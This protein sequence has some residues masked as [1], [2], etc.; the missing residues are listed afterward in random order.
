MGLKGRAFLAIW[1]GLRDGAATEFE[2][3]HTVEHMPERLGIP[4]FLRGRRYMNWDHKSHVC[5]TMYE[6]SH[7]E[8]F[9]SPA[10]LARLNAPTDWTRKVQPN[11]TGFLRGACENVF[12][13]GSG[14]AGAASVLRLRSQGDAS[15]LPRAPDLGVACIRIA[16]ST[17]ISGVHLGQHRP[18]I[19]SAPTKETELRVKGDD[20]GFDFLA[21]VEGLDRSYLEAAADK[22][23]EQFA[24]I[25]LEIADSGDYGLSYQLDNDGT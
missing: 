24:H 9:R 21:V 5:F 15:T 13:S 10:Y 2:Q 3:Y 12:S 11:M 14:V 16:A 20:S 18:E 22:V 4:G 25:G 19:A 6:A 7:L 8:V 17:G 23:R 1:H